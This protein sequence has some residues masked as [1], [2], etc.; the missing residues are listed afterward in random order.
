MSWWVY[1]LRCGDGT[2][3]TGVT[4]DLPRRLAAHAA[5]AGA[6]YTASRPPVVLAHSEPAIDRPAALRREAAIRKLGRAGKLALINTDRQRGGSPRPAH[7]TQL[8]LPERVAGAY[9]D[10]C[11]TEPGDPLPRKTATPHDP[12]R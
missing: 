2:L 4:N 12:A 8:E 10:G 11:R 6:R 7:P 5:G 1:I 9:T 3:Y